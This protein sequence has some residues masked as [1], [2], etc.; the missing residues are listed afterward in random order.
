MNPRLEQK[1]TERWP[2]WFDIQGD[3]RR[4][5]MP[6]GFAH[7]DGWFHILWCL[8]EELEPL[9]AEYEKETGC[10]FEVTSVKAKFGE[11]RFAISGGS[12]AIWQRIEHAQE[13]SMRICELCGKPGQRRTGSWIQTLCD[14]P[15]CGG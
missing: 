5:L 2:G 13:E 7:S 4:T 9:V 14:E 15:A 10:Q 11:L 6:F 8:C 3:L 1:F 12:D